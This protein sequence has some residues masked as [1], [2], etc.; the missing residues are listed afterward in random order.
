M[1]KFRNFLSDIFSDEDL[2]QLGRD[3]LQILLFFAVSLTIIMAISFVLN[4]F[5]LLG[6][7]LECIVI[8]LLVILLSI[9]LFSIVVYLYSCL[10]NLFRKS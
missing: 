8:I 5:T 3:C 1:R 6:N 10:K 7:I 4:T 2:I 9:A